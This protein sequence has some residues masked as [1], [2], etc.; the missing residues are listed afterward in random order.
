MGPA[1]TKE[2][3]STHTILAPSMAPI[4]FKLLVSVLK[5]EGYNVELL[6]NEGPQ[7]VHKGL[8]YVHND[9]CYPA[10]LVIGQ[11]IDALDS[12]KYDLNKVALAITQT[13][14]GCRASNYIHLLR[15]ALDKANYNHI[16]IV[17]MNLKGMNKNSGFRITLRMLRK[18]VAA[19]I[20]GDA[21]LLLKNQVTAYEVNRNETKELVNKWIEKLSN[22][23]HLGRGYSKKEL[24][25]FIKEMRDEFA[26]IKIDKSR[27]VIKVGVVGEIYMKYAPLGNNH[28][29]DFLESQQCE[30]MIPG[31]M[32]FVLYGMQNQVED[33]NLY[34]G[35]RLKKFIFKKINNY[36]LELEEIM[37]NEI[38]RE[39]RFTPPVA[40]SQTI[41]TAKEVIGIGCKMGEGWLLTA[42]MRDLAAQGY[43]NIICVQPFGCLPNHIVGKGMIRKLKELDQSINIVPI[44]YDPGATKVNQENRIKLMLAVA[45]EN[46]TKAL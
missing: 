28:L 23:F 22:E 13:G 3:R 29:E 15:K 46:R 34:G 24:A 35:S 5:D 42:E 40:F 2:M 37:I 38:G 1:F 32:G 8:T 7:V 16:P 21:L 4:Q 43:K 14:G 10:L 6:E 41:E 33:I 18:G 44:D 17:S 11:M 31:I 39:G 19:L 26:S 9:T 25:L 20:A 36:L 12:G 30:V 27:P 45:N